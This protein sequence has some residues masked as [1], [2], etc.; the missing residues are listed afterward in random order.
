MANIPDFL[1]HLPVYGTL[2]VPFFTAVDPITQRPNFRAH[3]PQKHAKAV[4]D[5][6]CGICGRTLDYW[7]AIIVGPTE[8]S[9][10]T[11]YMPAMH[12]RC[13]LYS[14]QACPFLATQQHEAGIR[15]G[16]QVVPTAQML[17]KPRRIALAKARNY[18]VLQASPVVGTE[19]VRFLEPIRVDW[20][21]YRDGKLEWEGEHNG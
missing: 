8:L 14:L 21:V 20:L 2:P 7:L 15:P 1:A 4:N 9:K 11:T 3:D 10:R 17:T 19:Y 16:D 13:A 6:L 12:E 5:H 18:R